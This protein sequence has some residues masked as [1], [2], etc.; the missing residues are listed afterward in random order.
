MYFLILLEVRNMYICK[1]IFVFRFG[2]DFFRVFWEKG[3]SLVRF[4]GKV[5]EYSKV[6]FKFLSF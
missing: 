6:I 4:E 5:L 3:F 2:K 1:L